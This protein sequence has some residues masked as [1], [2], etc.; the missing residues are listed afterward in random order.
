MEFLPKKKGEVSKDFSIQ[1]SQL[2]H[3]TGKN[4][5]ENTGTEY[6][7]AKTVAYSKEFHGCAK[8]NNYWFPK[9]TNHGALTKARVASERRETESSNIS[10]SLGRNLGPQDL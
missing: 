3:S 9:G 6:S 5:H 7:E 2:D 10:Y 4:A 8:H 1:E